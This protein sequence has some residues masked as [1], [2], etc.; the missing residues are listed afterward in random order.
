MYIHRHLFQNGSYIISKICWIFITWLN[1]DIGVEVC[2]YKGM[3]G[4]QQ[5]WFL[6]GYIL[7]LIA[8][9]VMTIVLC[10]RFVLFTRLFGRNVTKVLATFLFLM[11]SPLTNT[12]MQSLQCTPL[13]VST[14]NGTKKRLVWYFDGNVP[15]FGAKHIPL[16]MI[17]LSCAAVVIWFTFS[18]LLV[19]CLQRRANLFCFRWV[20]KFRPFFEAYSGSCHDNCQFWP[21]FLLFM[22]LGLYILYTLSATNITN[23]KT[24][25]Q[26]KLTSFGTT[27]VCIIILSLSCIFPH[28]AYKKWPINMLEF[29]FFLN[30]CITS[31]LWTIFEGH[32]N[33]LI[34]TTSVSI[35]AMTFLGTLAC[36]VG[37]KL[38][39]KVTI[40][41]YLKL[42]TWLIKLAQNIPFKHQIGVCCFPSNNDETTTLLHQPLPPVT[43]YGQYREPLIGDTNN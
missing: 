4:Y 19:Q 41:R 26:R 29:S 22:R 8:V 24:L 32:H 17:G 37:V 30:L 11:S 25:Y 16:F 15:C 3:D 28:G 36:H 5:I 14:P 43:Q 2:F 1:F 13:R 34:V 7:Y 20:E 38:R 27:L 42:K 18:L 33:Q 39:S 10:R 23:I 12:V 35:A 40:C 31:T 21:G 6:Y 9:Q